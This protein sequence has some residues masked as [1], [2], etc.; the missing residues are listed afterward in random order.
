MPVI[1]AMAF[2]AS[3]LVRTGACLDGFRNVLDNNLCFL[4]TGSIVFTA[5][6]VH[7]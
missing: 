1:S 7:P 3:E 4:I 2:T 6:S 5:L